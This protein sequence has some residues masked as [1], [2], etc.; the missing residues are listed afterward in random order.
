MQI[1]AVLLPHTITVRPYLGTGSYGDAYGDPV[2]VRRT[3][4]ED[5]R[6]LVRSTTGEEVISETTVR[7]R[8]VEHIPIGS[9]VTVWQGTPHERTGRVITV[10]LFDHPSSWPHIELALE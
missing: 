4:V 9:H 10:N 3:Y 6:R 5:R 1:P 7:T 2:I 8:P